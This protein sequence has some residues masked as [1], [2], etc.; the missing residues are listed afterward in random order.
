VAKFT[1]E[2]KA[3]W[4]IKTTEVQVDNKPAKGSYVATVDADDT[5]LDYSGNQFPQQDQDT[6]PAGT[7]ITWPANGNPMLRGNGGEKE[8]LAAIR[9]FASRLRA[10]NLAKV[11]VIKVK[12]KVPPKDDEGKA[13]SPPPQTGGG[14][15]IVPFLILV[16]IIYA[17]DSRRA[18]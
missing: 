3:T 7:K 13:Q 14:D 8:A 5:E 17:L 6:F 16:G 15:S 10:G 9:S 18:R 2:N 11:A 1:D 4:D 12:G